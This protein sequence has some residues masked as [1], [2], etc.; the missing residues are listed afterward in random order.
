MDLSI[1]QIVLPLQQAIDYMASL[2]LYPDNAFLLIYRMLLTCLHRDY[3]CD[4]H[5]VITHMKNKQ[6]NDD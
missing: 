6:I 1:K 2:N 3:R 5:N 4:C